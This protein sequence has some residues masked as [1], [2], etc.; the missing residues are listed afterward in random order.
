MAIFA[1][2]YRW[3]GTKTGE[4]EPIAWSSGAYDVKIF[5]SVSSSDKVQHLKLYV[6]I[7][8]PTGEGQSISANPE[9]FA[10]QICNDFSMDIERVLWVED[11]MTNE[12]RY[13]VISFTRSTKIGTTIFYKTTKRLA[14]ESELQLIERELVGMEI[15]VG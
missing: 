2:K 15:S 8:A 6:C 5:K 7:Y 4:R 1:G 14:L 9:K 11:L 3:E 13:E 12:D 10:K